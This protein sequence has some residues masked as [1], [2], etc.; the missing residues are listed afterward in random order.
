MAPGDLET[1][2]GV[3]RTFLSAL[4]DDELMQQAAQAVVHA[5]GGV[6]DL[7]TLM[8]NARLVH[9]TGDLGID[10]P[11]H[12]LT[13]VATEAQ[14]LEDR[15]L[16][17]E[18]AYFVFVWDVR[19]RGRISSG[20]LGSMLQPPPHDAVRDVYSTALAAL[21]E[22]DPEQ[23]VTDRT[24][25]VTVTSLRTALANIVLDADPPYP[26]EVSTQARRLLDG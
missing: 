3:V 14:R 9:Q 13:V 11:W 23:L 8:R 4:G 17:A 12:W 26:G 25:A 21:A 16:V 10:R 15:Q 6:P 2:R 18:I 7:E 19:L 24:G 1:A 20:E 5:G 22:V